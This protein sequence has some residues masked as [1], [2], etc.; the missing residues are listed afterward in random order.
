MM[1]V[2]VR[3]PDGDCEGPRT[4]CS[5]RDGRCDSVGQEAAVHNIHSSL[6]PQLHQHSQ[7]KSKL[8]KL[9]KKHTGTMTSDLSGRT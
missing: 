5:P 3:T 1:V 4:I 8:N 9:T 6:L 2:V 7:V